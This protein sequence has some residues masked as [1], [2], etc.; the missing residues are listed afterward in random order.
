VCDG[1]WARWSWKQARALFPSAVESL[2]DDHWS[3]HVH[4][5][6]VL[7]Y[8]AHPERQLAWCEAL[9][10]HLFWAEVHG[11]IW[12]LQ[13]MQPTDTHAA[14]EIGKLIRSLQRHQT[15]LDDRFARKGGSPLGSGGIDSANKVI[16]HVRLKRSG[17]WW[18]L[19]N[20]NQMLAL[21]GAK[22]HGTCQQVLS[23]TGNNSMIDQDKSL[24][25]S[26]ECSLSQ[27]ID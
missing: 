5:V 22:C 12:G 26:W 17:A 25:K 21:R 16:G 15:R 20:V 23:A 2:D 4:K 27:V 9:L 18:Y 3:A 10:A 24:L 14:E 7:P 11:V 19:T 13:R 8:G 1:G 6:A